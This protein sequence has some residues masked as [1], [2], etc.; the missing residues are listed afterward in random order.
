[1][2]SQRGP[3]TGVRCGGPA[4]RWLPA[5]VEHAPRRGGTGAATVARPTAVGGS[6]KRPVPVRVP[7]V[8]VR[9]PHGSL[10]SSRCAFWCS[11]AWVPALPRTAWAAA[12]LGQIRSDRGPGRGLSCC[13]LAGTVCP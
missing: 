12:F 1:M 13:S 7:P 6:G 9:V 11:L 5:A 10:A 8:P 4:G 3:V 2:R